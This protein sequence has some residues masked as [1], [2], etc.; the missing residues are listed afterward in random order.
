M[1]TYCFIDFILYDNKI[2][3]IQTTLSTLFL[4]HFPNIDFHGEAG[5]INGK[6]PDC[7]QRAPLSIITD[8]VHFW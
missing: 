1:P 3:P 2:Y 4:V 7:F 6:G 8:T 5:M